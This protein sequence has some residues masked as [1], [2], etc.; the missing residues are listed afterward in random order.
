MKHKI[1]L[2]S[3]F[4]DEGK[5]ATVQ[6]LCSKAIKENEKPIVARFSGGAQCGHRI[7]NGNI[8]HVC[9]SFG[10]GVL[11]GVPTYLNGNVYI[12]PISIMNESEEL[13]KKWG[14]Y[15]KIYIHEDCRVTTPFDIIANRK[16]FK[17]L[18]NGSCGEGIYHTFKRY[19]GVSTSLKSTIVE[20]LKHPLAFISDVLA[21]YS[22]DFDHDT[23][24]ECRTKFMEAIT[25]MREHVEIIDSYAEYRLF[26]NYDCII[27]EGSQ[28]LLLDMDC[29]FM[30]NCTPSRTGLNGMHPMYLKDAEVYL[31]MRSYLTRHGNGYNPVGE[32]LIRKHYINLEEPTNEDTG[33]Q[34]VFKIGAFDFEL[35]DRLIDRHHLDN[36][37]A[38]YNVKYNIVMT[39]MDCLTDIFFYYDRYGDTSGNLRSLRSMDIKKAVVEVL[40]NE[41]GDFINT[42][43]IGIGP[44][45]IVET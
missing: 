35:L 30:P 40:N 12:D 34:G 3:F 28:G 15:P 42:I 21:Y 29:G 24:I 44:D 16:D 1:V 38:M 8:E 41:Y 19:G 2:G 43:S 45:K 7:I 18:G 5:G 13:L 37:K 4:G 23:M 39:H 25:W 33:Y 32:K 31:V 9:S 17:V 20:A 14:Y 36:Y 22:Y 10:S 27:W 26:C 6:W 11:L